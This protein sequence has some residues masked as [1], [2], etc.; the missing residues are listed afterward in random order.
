MIAMLS[1]VTVSGIR[2]GK[3]VTASVKG[4]S[5]FATGHKTGFQG[6]VVW[7]SEPGACV[8]DILTELFMRDAARFAPSCLG[9]TFRLNLQYCDLTE[10]DFGVLQALVESDCVHEIQLNRC[11]IPDSALRAFTLLMAAHSSALDGLFILKSP[12]ITRHPAALAAL[13]TS[14]S[15]FGLKNIQVFDALLD[16]SVADAKLFIDAVAASAT[17]TIAQ[18]HVLCRE[19]V[20]YTLDVVPARTRTLKTMNL[21]LFGR[22]PGRTDEEKEALEWAE[23]KKSERSVPWDVVKSDPE[24]YIKVDQFYLP[25]PLKATYEETLVERLK[26]CHLLASIGQRWRTEATPEGYVHQKRQMTKK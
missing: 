24:N 26:A 2:K 4:A 10:A 13:G 8:S 1:A 12:S 15:N 22:P 3:T 14:I 6:D 5:L 9:C 16:A 18:A 11:N 25:A 17:L 7:V 23:A 21:A 19:L 20:E